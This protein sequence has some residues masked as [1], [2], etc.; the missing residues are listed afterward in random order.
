METNTAPTSAA[1][2][3]RT[4][5]VV[6]DA[7]SLASRAI[8]IAQRATSTA[9]NVHASQVRQTRASSRNVMDIGPDSTPWISAQDGR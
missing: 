2:I 7:G 6:E 8:S 4:G 3:R 1:A 5:P 9:K